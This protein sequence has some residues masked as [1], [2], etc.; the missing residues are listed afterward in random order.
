MA[1]EL[2]GDFVIEAMRLMIGH[3]DLR[4]TSPGTIRVT[5]LI[6]SLKI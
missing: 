3:R 5:F 4:L 1:M 2:E 6:P